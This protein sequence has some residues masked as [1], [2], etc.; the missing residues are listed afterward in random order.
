MEYNKPYYDDFP[1]LDND[2][3]LSL[4]HAYASQPKDRNSL[5]NLIYT[6]LEQCIQLCLGISLDFDK[7]MKEVILN[8]K[9]E[10][11]KVCENL[12]S[13]F[14]I[15]INI[16]EIKSFNIFT[17]IKKLSSCI[18]NFATW[19][20]GEEKQYYKTIAHSSLLSL[21]KIIKDITNILQDKNIKIYK[22][23]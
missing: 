14:S 2:A 21:C 7:K 8:S 10:L 20:Y 3:Y 17:F 12:K 13:S 9:N 1:I 11:D 18:E 19:E 22:Y 4:M 5:I 23:I 15:S 6:D 16:K